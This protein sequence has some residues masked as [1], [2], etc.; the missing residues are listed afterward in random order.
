M[1]ALR[2]GAGF[3]LIQVRQWQGSWAAALVTIVSTVADY[4]PCAGHLELT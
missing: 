1:N 3:H 4:L 2:H